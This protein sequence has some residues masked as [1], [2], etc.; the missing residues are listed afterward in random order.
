[1]IV[2][3]L[4]FRGEDVFDPDMI[5]GMEVLRHLHVYYAVNEQ[6][7]YITPASGPDLLPEAS[8]SVSS[9]RQSLSDTP[10]Q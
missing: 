8:A 6:K 2:R 10:A 3:P 9:V 4:E 1:M 5:I 7:L